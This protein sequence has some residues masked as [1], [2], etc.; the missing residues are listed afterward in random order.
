MSDEPLLSTAGLTRHFLL[1][2]MLDKQAL[3]AVD[4][5][6]LTIRER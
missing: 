4:D 1:G 2:G 5:L 6:D 3:H